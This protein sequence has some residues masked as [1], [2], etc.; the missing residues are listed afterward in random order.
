M[1]KL[2]LCVLGAL[3][4]SL[5]AVTEANAAKLT[6]GASDVISAFKDKVLDGPKGQVFGNVK[7]DDLTDM[8]KK[9]Q[10]KNNGPLIVISIAFLVAAGIGVFYVMRKK[11]EK[12]EDDEDDFPDVDLDE[13]DD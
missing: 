11:S 7:T 10:K 12:S 8:E 1:K 9:N 2:I 6:F 13:D 4:V 3:L 5:F